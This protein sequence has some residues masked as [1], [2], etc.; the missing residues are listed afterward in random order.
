MPGPTRAWAEQEAD[1]AEEPILPADIP[2]E[3]KQAVMDLEL[4]SLEKGNPQVLEVAGTV[5][6]LVTTISAA[7]A[8]DLVISTHPWESLMEGLKTVLIMVR[9]TIGNKEE[10]TTLSKQ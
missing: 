7:V 9:L 8:E 3:P 4:V 5:A 6:T 2:E 10:Y 1:S